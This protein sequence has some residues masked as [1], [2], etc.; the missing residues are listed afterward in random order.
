M[1][2]FTSRKT[3]LTKLYGRHHGRYLEL[4]ARFPLRPVRTEA[5]LDAAT[6]VIHELIDQHK[7]SAAEDDYLDVLSDLVEK[8]EEVHYPN[9]EVSDGGMLTYL[10]EVKDV[11]Q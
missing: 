9:E 4:L 5:E 1:A 6:E 10:M 2:T 7:R 3:P 11:T 8:Y